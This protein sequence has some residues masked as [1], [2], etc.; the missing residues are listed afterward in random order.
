MKFE[1]T[2]DVL[3]GEQ[4]CVLSMVPSTCGNSRVL[5]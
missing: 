4:R 2:Q 1:M 3:G 5:V